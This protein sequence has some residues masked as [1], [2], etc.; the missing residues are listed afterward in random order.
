M[1]TERLKQARV[2]SLVKQ[3][4]KQSHETML[5]K[6]DKL[7]KSNALFEDIEKWKEDDAPMVLPK[8]IVAAVLDTEVYQ[9]S[10]VG[11]S[12]E[13]KIKKKTKQIRYYL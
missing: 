9:Y 13:K 2:H 5:E 10:A 1:N 7:L 8:C 12:F 6:V 11:T 4:L 3:M